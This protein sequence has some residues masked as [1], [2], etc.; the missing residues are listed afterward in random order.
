[1][2][3]MTGAKILAVWEFDMQKEYSNITK[4]QA[5][6]ILEEYERNRFDREAQAKKT[7]NCPV[8]GA[9]RERER[10]MS[11]FENEIIDYL[12]RNRFV[13]FDSC[14]VCVQKHVGCAIQYYA[15]MLKASNSGMSDST[16]KIDIKRNHLKVIGELGCAI[17]ESTEY[18]E[19][20]TAL[21]AEERKYRY[22]GIEPDWEYIIALIVKYEDIIEAAGANK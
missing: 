4:E 10:T 17:D 20:H 1:M 22:E 5:D 21:I 18:T 2:V 14:I 7:A 12:K 9:R 3:V 15:E 11:K 8:C 6:K 16:A 19:L 13:R